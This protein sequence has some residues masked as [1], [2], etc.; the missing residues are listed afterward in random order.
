MGSFREK[1]SLPVKKKPSNRIWEICVEELAE[2]GSVLMV[3]IAHVRGGSGVRRACSVLIGS[4]LNFF[5]L[6]A[7][8]TQRFCPAAIGLSK[9][10]FF[11]KRPSNT[12]MKDLKFRK[13]AFVSHTAGSLTSSKIKGS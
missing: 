11:C 12:Q 8:I 13:K 4:I 5:Y 1:F 10:A 6:H 2:L 9:Q 3:M 7:K